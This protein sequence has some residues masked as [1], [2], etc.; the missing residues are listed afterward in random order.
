[1]NALAKH[2]LLVTCIVT[3]AAA[4]CTRNH[5]RPIAMQTGQLDSHGNGTSSSGTNIDPEDIS[6]EGRATGIKT[7]YFDYNSYAL[8]PDAL[9]TLKGNTT[10]FTRAIQRDKI[11]VEGH[12]DE[13]GTQEYNLALGEQRA[14]TVRHH[15]INLGIDGARISTLSYGEEHPADP[16]QT[17]N[18]YALNRR[19][20]FAV[21]AN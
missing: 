15:L 21:H 18:A 5:P 9:M 7:V 14:L 8:R 4:G 20:E 6:A 10:I 1:M 2:A 3:L 12:C 17:E 16:A 11:Q 13:R 19:C